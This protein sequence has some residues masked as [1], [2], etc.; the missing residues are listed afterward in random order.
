[1][2]EGRELEREVR[3]VWRG[4]GR[5]LKR[6]SSGNLPELGWEKGSKD[7]GL[8]VEKGFEDRELVLESRRNFRRI[9]S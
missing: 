3:R 7:S 1:M 8:R 9:G 4:L 2:R 6:L 5:R